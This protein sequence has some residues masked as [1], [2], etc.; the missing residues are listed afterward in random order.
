MGLFDIFNS[1]NADEARDK[2]VAA[3]QQGYRQASELLG[4]GRDA[5]TQ[6][7]TAGLQPYQ[8]NYQ[9]GQAG[10]TA[11]ADVTGANGPEGFARAVSNF[12]NSPGFQSAIDTGSE[13]VLRN[14]ARTGDLRSGATNI[15]LQNLAQNLQNQ[16][17]QQYTANLSPFLGTSAQAA[18]GI[19]ALNS[20]LGNQLN[21]SFGDQAQAVYNMNAG[22][23]NAEANAALASN[24]A[25]ANGWGAIMQGA[26]LLASALP[27]L[28][29]D[30]RIKDEIEPV[31]ELFDGQTIYRYRYKGDPSE[32]THIGVLAQEAEGVNP[33]AVVEF[34][35]VKAVDYRKAT[36]YAAGLAQ[37]LEAA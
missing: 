19:G 9:T 20:G 32:A 34:G 13:N 36:D 35:G 8:Q 15:D 28:P 17:W 29:S 23:G 21:A 11:Y 10:Q 5:L 33:D 18:S 27:F 37:M 22:I 12:Q 24:N 26:N 16:Q 31:G 3:L 7:Y 30:E 6:Y 25:S 1:D 4:S 14:R 2:Q